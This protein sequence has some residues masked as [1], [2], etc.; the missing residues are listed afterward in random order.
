MIQCASGPGIPVPKRQ[1][2]HH[3]DE[4]QAPPVGDLEVFQRAARGGPMTKQPAIHGKEPVDR[5][6]GGPVPQHRIGQ[7][8]RHDER[9]QCHRVVPLAQ[10]QQQERRGQQHT[11]GGQCPESEIAPTV[12]LVQQPHADQ[13]DRQESNAQKG[14][15]RLGQP[16]VQAVAGDGAVEVVAG[17]A[18][19][20][21]GAAQIVPAVDDPDLAGAV[22]GHQ[23]EERGNAERGGE[24]TPLA[25]QQRQQ[26]QGSQQRFDHEREADGNPGQPFGF[27]GAVQ[28]PAE[29]QH[30]QQ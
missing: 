6:P 3:D 1:H 15:Q 19:V 17:F 18:Q 4:Q 13:G 25:I 7:H 27:L 30:L 8:D 28:Q 21:H 11:A 5:Q 26:Q 22:Q 29:E 2:H 24:H 10:A 14:D 9:E 12:V 16:V 23:I 20:L